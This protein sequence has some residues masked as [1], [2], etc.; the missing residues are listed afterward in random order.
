[1]PRANGSP[2]PTTELD[3]NRNHDKSERR[4]EKKERVPPRSL[5][6]SGSR[7]LLAS[8]EASEASWSKI[9]S[10]EVEE[11]AMARSVAADMRGRRE[12]TSDKATRSKRNTAP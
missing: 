6:R 4:E 8:E 1:M 9:S 10:K 3:R 5:R 12:C 11:S 7:A 2:G